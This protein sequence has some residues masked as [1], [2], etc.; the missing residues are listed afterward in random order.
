LQTADGGFAVVGEAYLADMAGKDVWLLKLDSNGDLVWT[1]T[2]STTDPEYGYGIAQAN[3]GGFVVTGYQETVVSPDQNF[4][5][6]KFSSSG[7]LAWSTV[8]DNGGFDVAYDVDACAD[9]GFV[10][11]GRSD[12]G[13]SGDEIVALKFDEVGQH[14]WTVTTGGASG[15]GS[16]EIRQLNSGGYIYCGYSAAQQ[17][18]A[19]F[20]YVVK[21]MPDISLEGPLPV[22][23]LSFTAFP[24]EAGIM[25]D[26]RTASESDLDHY[27][28]VRDNIEISEFSANNSATESE[29]SFLDQNVF[30][31]IEY[32]YDLF[33]VSTAGERE[34]LGTR[35]ASVTGGNAIVNEFA[36]FQNYPNPF[37][38]ETSIR[39]NLAEASEVN[40]TVFNVAGQ[41]VAELANGNF[42]SGMHTVNFDAANLTSGVYLYRVTAGS[43]TAQKKM[44]L[45]K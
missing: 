7:A 34:W 11:C 25:V 27:A 41:V 39:F 15:D 40:L 13:S 33:A 10:I 45:M 2:F 26:W 8:F 28:L 20:Y 36:L 38:P 9:G 43:F 44:V 5:L 21:L 16:Y 3:D 31:G 19:I 14:Y 17:S 42:S 18:E 1:A 12:G 22:E 6:V 4:I 37:N 32:I 29:Y 23:L 24:R 30:N 35:T